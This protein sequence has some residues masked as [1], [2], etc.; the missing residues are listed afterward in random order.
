MKRKVLAAGATTAEAPERAEAVEAS[1]TGALQSRIRAVGSELA[2][3]LAAVLGALPGSPLRPNQLVSVLGVN[4]AV[5]SKVLGATSQRDPMAVLHQVPGPE[6]LRRLLRAAGRKGVAPEILAR[7]GAAV[8]D[9]DRLIRSEAGTR[10]ALDALLSASL[11]DARERLEL[12]S[13]YS[14]YKGMSQLKGAL[15]E[16]WVGAAIV[17][18]SADDAQ[19]HD[20]TWLNGAVGIQR[21]RPGVTV[22]FSYR[23]RRGDTEVDDPGAAHGVVP[24]DRFCENPPARLEAREAG[25]TIHYTLPDDLLGPRSVVDM[26]VVDHHPAAMRRTTDAADPRRNSL[27]VE[28]AIPVAGL[29]FDVLLHEDAFP[30]SEPRL[31]V[32]DT[33]YD[34]IAN[35]NDRERDIDR[36]DLH[37]SV[38]FLGADMR[39]VQAAELPRY[40]EML[41]HLAER[42]GWEP[43][44]LRAYRT[45]IQYPVYGW[46]VCLSFLPPT[47]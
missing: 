42:F 32:Y 44:R 5:A 38:E 16:T 40:G 14:V 4:R 11:P 37:E 34:G 23:H 12:A 39:R 47:G 15:A 18:P 43:E 24:L 9:F 21:L 30:G 46:Q 22:R 36:V 2:A 7:A 19:K 25:G 6:P 27:F 29:V 45:R 26:F 17:A 33:G 13:K 28:P 10:P 31:L 8:T 35:V 20:L 3:C 41:M 1:G